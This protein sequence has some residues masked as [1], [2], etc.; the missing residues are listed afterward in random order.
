MKS[1]LN[2]SE[3]GGTKFAED[4]PP[5]Y[6]R[7]CDFEHISVSCPLPLNLMLRNEFSDGGH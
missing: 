4:R 3:V 2:C 5:H 1:L 6:R 7:I